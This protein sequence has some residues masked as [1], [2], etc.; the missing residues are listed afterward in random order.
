MYAAH[1]VVIMEAYL[2]INEQAVVKQVHE[3]R[4]ACQPARKGKDSRL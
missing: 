4:F 1:E 3:H 2:G